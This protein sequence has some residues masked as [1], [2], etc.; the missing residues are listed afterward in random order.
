MLSIAMSLTYL[1]W[2]RLYPRDKFFLEDLLSEYLFGFDIYEG[3]TGQNIDLVEKF[4][5]GAVCFY[6]FIMSIF[7]LFLKGWTILI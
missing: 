1:F 6:A 4:G 3:K 7:L 2:S 5:N